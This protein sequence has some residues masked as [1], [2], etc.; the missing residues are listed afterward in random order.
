MQFSGWGPWGLITWIIGMTVPVALVP[1]AP[2]QA[3]SNRSSHPF[4]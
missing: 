4:W 1:G 2:A 3:V